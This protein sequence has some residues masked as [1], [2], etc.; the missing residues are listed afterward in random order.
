VFQISSLGTEVGIDIV[1][2]AIQSSVR[3]IAENFR[4]RGL[5]SGRGTDKN[6]PNF[7]YDAQSGD[8]KD[9]VAAAVPDPTK[10]PR[11]ALRAAASGRHGL[12]ASSPPT[13]TVG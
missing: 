1:R 5:D 6:A 3:Q 2:R 13:A 11:V 9:M 10:V 7:G 4:R 8:D 12:L